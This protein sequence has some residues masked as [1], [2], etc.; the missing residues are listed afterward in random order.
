MV[1]TIISIAK[2]FDLNIVAEGVETQKQFDTLKA[3]EC[4]I[5]QGFYFDEAL[6]QSDFEKK[7]LLI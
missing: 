1:S 6:P 4:D 7:Y 5:Y 2:N 3:Y